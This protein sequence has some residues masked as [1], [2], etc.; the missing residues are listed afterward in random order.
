[1][2]YLLAPALGLLLAAAVPLAAADP[3][4]PGDRAVGPVTL[5]VGGE[6]L[7]VGNYRLLAI[8]ID[9]Y[10][11]ADLRLR[12]AVAGAR[13][14]R[15]ILVK[16]YTFLP[17]HCQLLLDAQATR[18]G[19]IDA[20]R[21]LARTAV[22]EDSILIYYAGHG[23]VDTMTREG[24]WVPADATAATPDKWISNDEIKKLIGAMKARH[25]LLI[26]DSCFAGDFF[27]RDLNP[28]GIKIDDAGLRRAFSRPSRAAMTAGGIEPVV[29][30]GV[31]PAGFP[32]H[33]VYTGWLLH[34]L[35]DNHDPYV[36]PEDLHERLRNAVS[37]NAQQKPL[38]GPLG[39]AG[40]EPDASFVFFRCGTAS[41]D[42]AMRDRLARIEELK[43]LNAEAAGRALR[44]QQEIAAKQ[45]ALD[46][47]NRKLAELQRQVGPGGA[48]DL[49]AILATGR[50]LK[51]QADALE[52][53][54]RQAEEDLKRQEAA[55]AAARAAQ[56]AARVQ[57]F[58]SDLAK[59]REIAANQYLTAEMKARAWQDLC[60]RW[61]VPKD[62]QPGDDLTYRDGAVFIGLPKPQP[63]IPGVMTPRPAATK[64]PVEGQDY[65]V[66][67]LGM[68][69][70]WVKALNGW[71]GKYEVTNGEYRKM[72][73][74]HESQ[75]YKE[76]TVN[77]Y[78]QPVVYVNW[79]DA[80][81]YAKW[82]TDQERAAGR[83]PADS[84]YRVPSEKEW[85]T[86]ASCGDN[87]K[88]PWGN[89]W[90]PKYG[91]YAG[92][93]TK[94]PFDWN[95]IEGYTDG[96]LVTCAVEKSGK[97]DWGLYGMGGNVWEICADGGGRFGAWRGA[98][99]NNLG[100]DVMA[101]AFRGVIGGM[102]RGNNV[103]FR[104]FLSR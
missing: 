37:A 88:F 17:D 25:V 71:M 5:S 101:V 92:D 104:L 34:V 57:A 30:A 24:S 8:G 56:E 18:A 39:G 95:V 44:Q 31:V 68:E 22:P 96:V 48:T 14:L 103:G 43:K 21:G 35:A 45:S 29:D 74:D 80:V 36:T 32:G 59:Y 100:Q 42:A 7:A 52:A 40:G 81:A 89:D 75:A 3:P 83:L 76:H 38:Y 60:R 28:R 19:I 20:L 23:Q 85:G 79:D 66:P 16:D 64:S 72:K 26:S 9:E 61:Q 1:M 10:L 6:D 33:S 47:L 70:V 55:V 77:G 82:L 98:S 27:K 2:R 13:A 78:R 69:F 54:R 50:E 99:W 49:D 15:E 90:P 102:I 94:K 67:E 4:P 12:T 97:N 11:A 62:A 73:P 93:E 51:R 53:L 46:E 84:A 58:A 87:R 41:V 63:T 65:M 91:N 86:C